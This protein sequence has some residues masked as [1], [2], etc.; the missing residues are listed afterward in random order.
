MNPIAFKIDN[1]IKEYEELEKLNAQATK[2]LSDIDLELSSLYHKIEG[3]ETPNI[4][5]S[6]KLIKELKVILEKRRNIKLEG[7]LLRA[8]CDTLK[9]KFLALK[10]NYN[11]VLRK[12]EDVINEIKQRVND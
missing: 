12:N 3:T 1:F 2:N 8:T 9:D 11:R 7:L 6:Y 10:S 4:L 5:Q